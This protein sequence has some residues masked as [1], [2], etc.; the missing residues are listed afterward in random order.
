MVVV[1]EIVMGDFL[2]ELS[3]GVFGIEF[4]GMVEIGK[5]EFCFIFVLEYFVLVC[6]C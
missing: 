1:V 6:K 4:D 2:I 5:G 3:V